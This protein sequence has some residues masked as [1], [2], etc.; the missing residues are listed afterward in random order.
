M[1][2]LGLIMQTS[3]SYWWMMQVGESRMAYRRSNTLRCLARGGT[4]C[5]HTLESLTN[6]AEGVRIARSQSLR[7]KD[8]A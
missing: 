1:G 6:D 2:P 4:G 5:G 3:N 7:Q 8:R